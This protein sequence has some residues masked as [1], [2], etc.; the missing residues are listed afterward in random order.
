MKKLFIGLV[1]VG[2]M[3][4]FTDVEKIIENSEELS[5]CTVEFRD[6]DGNVTAT[7]HGATCSEA[8]ARAVAELRGGA[9][10]SDGEDG[11]DGAD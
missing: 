9:D 11:R 1:I 6:E 2:T 8:R 4:S 7:G 5:G 10:G 3:M